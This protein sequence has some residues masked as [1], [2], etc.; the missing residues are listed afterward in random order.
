[1]VL[2][3]VGAIA[4]WTKPRPMRFVIQGPSPVANGNGNIGVWVSAPETA[5]VPIQ[6]ADGTRVTVAAGARARIARADTEGV[7]IMVER[8]QL[9]FNVVHH[10]RTRWSIATG[11][12][13]DEGVATHARDVVKDG[14]L[15]GY[16]LS[17]YSARKLGLQSTGNAGGCHNMLMKPTVKDDFEAMLKRLGTG[18]LVTELMGQGVNNVTGDYSR[19]AVGFWV[20]NGEI[21]FP[22]EEI[23][24]AGNMKDMLK[25]IV[26]VGNDVLALGSKQV[27]SILIE[28]MA[29][30]G[31]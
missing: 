15:Q 20:E 27:G 25:G 2:G 11:P 23:T 16:F 14:V 3:G 22:V 5:P 10:D 1:M 30:A 9:G 4:L 19:G 21:A 28:H 31:E 18:L 26:A 24:I 17:S 13:D 29:V 12:F 6:F 7:N 8:G